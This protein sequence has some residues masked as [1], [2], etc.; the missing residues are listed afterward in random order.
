MIAE[1]FRNGKKV[2]EVLHKGETFSTKIFEEDSRD[3]NLLKSILK[4]RK[5]TA[6]SKMDT[7]STPGGSISCRLGRSVLET[8]LILERGLPGFKTKIQNPPKKQQVKL[9]E[10]SV[11]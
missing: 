3:G 6:V 9:D 7:T 11:S 2:G 4:Y 5:E 10:E 1:I 8:F